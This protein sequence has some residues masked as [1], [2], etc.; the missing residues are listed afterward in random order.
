MLSQACEVTV[1]LSCDTLDNQ[2]GAEVFAR[3]RHTANVLMR[4][5]RQH[6]VQVSA[7][8]VLEPGIRFAT[9]DLKH[10]EHQIFRVEKEPLSNVPDVITLYSGET[11]YHEAAYIGATIRHLMM[12]E[13]YQ[14][15]DFAIIARSLD[16]YRGVLDVALE[17]YEVPYFMDTPR[18]VYAEPLMCLVL[19]ALQILKSNFSSDDMFVYLK[20]GLAGLT[21]YEISLLENYTFLWNL[22]GK[23]WL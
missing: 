15:Q 4:M 19:Y 14:Y 10:L 23:K 12:N 16:H 2:M 22:S 7:P 13:G 3:V 11:V 21:P 5:A 17:Q 18:S 9:E 8:I 20:T 1:S 6:H